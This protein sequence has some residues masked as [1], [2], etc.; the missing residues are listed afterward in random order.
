MLR[1][2]LS[3]ALFGVLLSVPLAAQ[4]AVG[5][6]VFT[7]ARYLDYQTVSD[8][9]PSPDGARVVYTRRWV[10]KQA[11]RWESELW[12]VGADGGRNR[13]FAKGSS[14]VWSPDGT[15]IAYVAEGQPRGTQVWV[16]YVDDET[17][18]QITHLDEA[19]SDLRW[20]PDGTWVG[21]TALVPASDTW[22]IEMPAAPTGATWT[23]APR[24]V[25]GLYYRF[26]RRG[27]LS[28]ANRH[29]FVVPA[30]GGAARQVT[31]GDWSVGSSLG[32]VPGGAD[33]EWTPDGRTMIF[34]G[35][36]EPE[37]E[38][39]WRSAHLYAADVATGTVRRLTAE[40]GAWGQPRLSPDGQTLAYT[41]TPQGTFS[42]RTSDLYAMRL[43]GTGARRLTEGF[44]RSPDNVSW[45]PD[46][47]R[48][49]FT[50]EDRGHRNAYT[51]PATGGTP[52][53][54]TQGAHMLTLGAL[55]RSPVAVGVR[56]GPQTPPD[57]VRV[58]LRSG[59]ITPL[60]R[61]NAGLMA[62][63]RLG[64]VEELWY[65]SADG[66]RIQ[67]WIVKP[68]DYDPA[69][70]YPLLME[71]HGGPHA[72]Y[73][74]GFNPAFQNFAAHGYLVLYTNPRGS[75]GYGSA[76]GNAIEKAYPSVDH[77]DLMA[78]VDAVVARGVVDT[79]RVFVGGCSG[80]GVLSSW[81]IAHTDRFAAAAV[82]CPVTNWLSMAGQTDI[83]L[84]TYNF[85]EQPFWENPEPWLRYSPLMH[86][87]RVNTPTLVMTGELDLRTPMAQS[88]EYYAALKMRGVPSE[89]LRF[90]GEYHGTSSIPSNWMRTQLYMMSWYDRWGNARAARSGGSPPTGANR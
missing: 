6:D 16:R 4:P 62:G 27:F 34:G 70:R 61:V 7:V 15:R 36:R 12:I 25:T 40:P 50:A 82:R 58:D 45:T 24:R 31:K 37:A 8:P 41:G 80:G 71:I 47:R 89:L 86:V 30:D 22:R 23:P 26:D 13:F 54:I 39:R 28:A 73:N 21:F 53:L 44:D 43:D 67:G 29:L 84:F 60:T 85:F 33:W 51:V 2:L 76:F 35:F 14:P 18:S 52:R 83:P 55:G 72:M 56:T 46:G 38:R 5:P 57:V 19:P 3:L 81:A 65:N 90:N 1:R 42:Y 9:V 88:E 17:G 68:P 32:E 74:V 87:G 75:T 48:L 66:T 59:D 20:S 77:D 78:G 64:E 63:L 10:N 69:R 11:D 79:S 49:V